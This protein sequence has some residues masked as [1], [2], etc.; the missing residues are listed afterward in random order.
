[1]LMWTRIRE[2]KNEANADRNIESDGYGSNADKM[3]DE[4]PM[5]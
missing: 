1:M 3:M 4:A 5:H 2:L